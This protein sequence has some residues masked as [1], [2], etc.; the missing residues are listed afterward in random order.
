MRFLASP[1]FRVL[2]LG[3]GLLICGF[4]LSA[5]PVSDGAA[6][7][8]QNCAMCHGA[9]GKGFAAIKT[10][11]FTDPKWQAS[12]NGQRDCGGHQERQEGHA[13]AGLRREAKGSGHPDAGEVHSLLW[14]QQGKVAAY[15]HYSQCC[16]T[17]LRFC[18]VSEKRSTPWVGGRVHP[19]RQ[20]SLAVSACGGLVLRTGNFHLSSEF[21]CLPS[22]RVRGSI[23]FKLNPGGRDKPKNW[24]LR[25]NAS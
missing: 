8:Q 22:W 7:Y 24:T 6:L 14:Q 4:A 1:A 16:W 20:F 19:S 9:D 17:A 21:R 5:A 13:H 15:R 18:W 23:S 25:R 10:P 11:D 12:R 2:G 3:V